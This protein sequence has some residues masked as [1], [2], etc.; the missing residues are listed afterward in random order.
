MKLS[1][2]HL[3]VELK[4]FL[5]MRDADISA[6]YLEF[7]ELLREI[8]KALDLHA[9][10]VPLFP[11]RYTATQLHKAILEAQGIPYGKKKPTQ[12]PPWTKGNEKWIATIAKVTALEVSQSQDAYAINYE[13]IASDGKIYHGEEARYR[14]PIP[15]G[16][17]WYWDEDEVRENFSPGKEIPCLV[18]EE[19]PYRHKIFRPR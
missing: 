11:E 2:E 10:E 18:S 4:A 9:S 16:S 3:T 6:R 15:P 7:R 14:D 12:D 1:L 19:S 13:Y 8:A 5:E 17:W